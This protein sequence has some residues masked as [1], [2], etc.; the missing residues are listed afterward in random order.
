MGEVVRIPRAKKKKKK[1]LD[2]KIVDPDQAP[3]NADQGVYYLPYAPS[4]FWHIEN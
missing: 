1:K 4:S 2:K 3:P